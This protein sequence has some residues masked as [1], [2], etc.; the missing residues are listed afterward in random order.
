LTKSPPLWW[1]RLS[2]AQIRFTSLDVLQNY[3][4]V[5]TRASRGA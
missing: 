5:L 4:D 2:S 3:L 1:M